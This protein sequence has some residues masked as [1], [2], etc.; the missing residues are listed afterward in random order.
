MFL[1]CLEDLENAVAIYDTIVA[2]DSF[3]ASSTVLV[4]GSTLFYYNYIE[5]KHDNFTYDLDYGL[6]ILCS[7]Y[8]NISILTFPY[9]ITRYL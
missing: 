9:L 2:D 6:L 5:S 1:F 7:C 8:T 3:C 4:V